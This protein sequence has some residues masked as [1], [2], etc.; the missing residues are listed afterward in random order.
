M[1]KRILQK[2]YFQNEQVVELAKDLLGKFLFTNINN[3]LTGGMITETEAYAGITDKGSH[4]YNGR[5]TARTE[6]MYQT[7]GISYVYFTYGIHYLFNVVTGKEGVPHA[8]LIRAVYPLF[9]TDIMLQRT[10]KKTVDYQLTNGPAKLTKS[11]GITKDQNN[12]PLD[13]ETLWLEERGIEI[14]KN[15]VTVTPRIGINYAGEDAL[16]PYRF[17]LNYKNYLN[18][19]FSQ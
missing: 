2:E 19:K 11:L 17:V 16:L 15:D 9:G 13:G 3:H 5:R 4:A 10:E 7:G 14:D 1:K 6:V 18:N 8:V 12:I